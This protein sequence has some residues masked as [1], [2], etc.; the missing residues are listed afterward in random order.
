MRYSACWGKWDTPS[1]RWTII[2]NITAE[3]DRQG[4]SD[5]ELGRRINVSEGYVGNLMKWRRLVS[6]PVLLSICNALNMSP[7]DAL[8]GAWEP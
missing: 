5:A 8:K 4:M 2:Q 6:L 3:L 7:N 1:R